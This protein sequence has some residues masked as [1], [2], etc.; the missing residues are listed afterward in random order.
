M[1][2]IILLVLCISMLVPSVKAEEENLVT[3]NAKSAILIE[4]ET[5]EV[6]YEY[7]SKF[8]LSKYLKIY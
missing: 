8:Y 2:K 3:P 4:A 1:K 7:N 5:G 6:L